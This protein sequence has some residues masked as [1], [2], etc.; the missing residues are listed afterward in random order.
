MRGKIAIAVIPFM[1]CCVISKAPPITKMDLR[2]QIVQD[3][4]QQLCENKKEELQKIIIVKKEQE[5]TEKI[6]QEPQNKKQHREYYD[7]KLSK[8][9]QDYTYQLCKN[10]GLDYELVLAVMYTES[11][12]KPN[13]VSK[14]NDYGLM[15]INKCNHGWI[16]RDLGLN[17]MLD[18]K[19]NIQAGVAMLNGHVKKYG[20]SH[21]ALMAYNMGTGGMKKAVSRGRSSSTYSRL[22]L[23][24]RKDLLQNKKF[25]D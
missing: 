21:K 22:I 9:L 5:K 24:R 17:N 6:Q 7:I 4:V 13:I 23:K 11:H 14:T 2:Q 20:V 8:E 12:F 1:M 16:K 19:Q 10:K 25:I 15:Q 18:P 3:M